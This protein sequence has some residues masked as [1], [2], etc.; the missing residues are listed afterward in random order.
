V[1]ALPQIG[2]FHEAACFAHVPALC[3]RVA[4]KPVGVLWFNPAGG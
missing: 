4:V 1:L 3:F 2:M